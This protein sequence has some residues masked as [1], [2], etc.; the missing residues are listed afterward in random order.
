[1]C[2]DAQS[3]G[4]VMADALFTVPTEQLSP[5]GNRRTAQKLGLDPL[6]FEQCVLDPATDQRIERESKILR[7]NDLQGL[8]T[9]YVGGRRIVGAQS[10]DVFREAFEAAKRGA[11]DRG[12]PAPV[13]VGI[14]LVLVG[15]VVAA[16]RKRKPA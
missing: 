4:D 15:A 9:T 12:I 6:R 8:P 1:V 10:E 2:A 13:Y 16:G 3:K 5:M 7:D 14:C 11:D